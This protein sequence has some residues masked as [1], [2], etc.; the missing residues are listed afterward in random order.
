MTGPFLLHRGVFAVWP[1]GQWIW[2]FCCL[3]THH[4]KTVPWLSLVYRVWWWKE[5][6]TR[7]TSVKVKTHSIKPAQTQWTAHGLMG[8]L[9]HP[10]HQ[11][12][13]QKA[14]GEDIN[15]SFSS[16]LV[17]C[18][19][20]CELPGVQLCLGHIKSEPSIFYKVASEN[21]QPLCGPRLDDS[22]APVDGSANQIPNYATKRQFVASCHPA[23]PSRLRS[24]VQR[25]RNR[26]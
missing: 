12:A 16:R 23:E 1:Q 20:V 6:G 11:A 26:A 13:P 19:C 24:Q 21:P 7:F 3:E 14:S 22:E 18:R 2:H 4:T 5:E 10:Q 9:D 15:I 17:Y 8:R 25:K